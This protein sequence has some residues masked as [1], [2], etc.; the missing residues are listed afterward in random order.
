MTGLLY[1]A[2]LGLD[3][4]MSRSSDLNPVKI[5]RGNRSVDLAR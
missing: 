1:T 2:V 4:L 3:F 5:V